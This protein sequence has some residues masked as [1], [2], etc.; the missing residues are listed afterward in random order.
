MKKAA[1]VA[2]AALAIG[3]PATADETAATPSR[4]ILDAALASDGAY[5][6]AGVAVRPHR[7]PALGLEAARAGGRLEPRPRCATG[8]LDRV[9]TEKVMVP[10]WVRGDAS[11]ADPRPD[12]SRPWRS[13]R[14]A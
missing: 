11:G 3:S 8:R 1:I 14:S 12:R 9:R 5:R 7:A 4:R 13:S 10:N 2:L 6:Q